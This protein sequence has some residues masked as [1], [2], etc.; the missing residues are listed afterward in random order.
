[1]ANGDP[2]SLGPYLL[3]TLARR[4][5]PED[6]NLRIASRHF[7][8]L[9]FLVLRA[10]QLVAKDSLVGTVWRD[11]AVTNGSL[12]QATYLLRRTLTMPSG[13]APVGNAAWLSPVGPMLSTCWPA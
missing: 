8:L 12:D 1:M 4:L 13:K 7:D 9:C 3:D 2:L 6:V 10:G 11:V 5:K